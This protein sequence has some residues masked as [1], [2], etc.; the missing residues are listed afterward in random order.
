MRNKDLRVSLSKIGFALVA[1]KSAGK[2]WLSPDYTVGTKPKELQFLDRLL[3]V[4]EERHAID[5]K[6]LIA[7]GFSAGGMMVWNLACYRAARFKAFVPIAGTFWKP[8]PETCPGPF[9]T[10]SHVHGTADRIVPL[11]GRKLSAAFQQGNVHAAISRYASWGNYSDRPRIYRDRQLACRRFDAND[12]SAP[13]FV[14]LCLHKRGH[15]YAG[16]FI[17]RV[18]RQVFNL[19]PPQRRKAS[20]RR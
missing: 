19:G 16:R 11:K 6:R 20:T 12:D 5:P 3:D 7:A 9:P 13:R 8:M 17:T 2:G 10:L 15:T 18:A 4:L 14:E 1:P